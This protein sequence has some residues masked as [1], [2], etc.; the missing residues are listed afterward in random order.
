M[1]AFPQG[2]VLSSQQVGLTEIINKPAL[3]IAGACPWYS[4]MDDQPRATGEAVC[5]A[6]LL[7]P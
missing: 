1:F 6:F 7:D 3:N 2:Q 4:H 5:T